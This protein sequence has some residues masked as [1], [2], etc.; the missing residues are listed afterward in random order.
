MEWGTQQIIH[1]RC[2][3]MNEEE[4]AQNS[5]DAVEVEQSIDDKKI[6]KVIRRWADYPFI[7]KVLNKQLMSE[8]QRMSKTLSQFP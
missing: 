6:Y 2:G 3:D 8:R 1:A 5:E 4:D 7:I